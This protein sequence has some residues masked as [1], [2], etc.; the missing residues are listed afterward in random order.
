MDHTRRRQDMSE[1]YGDVSNVTMQLTIDELPLYEACQMNN[2]LL[3]VHLTGLVVVVVNC[4]RNCRAFT[5]TH[6][7]I[8]SQIIKVASPVA[9]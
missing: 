2:H 6:T 7:H 3:V 5:H 4:K 1:I 8:A 9:L